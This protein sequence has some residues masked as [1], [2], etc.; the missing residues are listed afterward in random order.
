MWSPWSWLVRDRVRFAR[1]AAAVF[2]ALVDNSHRYDV[3][4][5]AL[6]A[7]LEETRIGEDIAGASAVT[8]ALKGGFAWAVQSISVCRAI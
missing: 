3:D 4:P 5:A 1:M 2:Q 8:V 7:T 6:R